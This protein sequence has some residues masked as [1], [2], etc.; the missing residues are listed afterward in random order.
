MVQVLLPQSNGRSGLQPNSKV[1]SGSIS[2]VILLT[3]GI[4][5]LNPV[6]TLYITHIT[7]P[8]PTSTH[9]RTKLNS[10]VLK[11]TSK[12]LNTHSKMASKLLS[13]N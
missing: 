7:T 13:L 1:A 9:G 6:L 8:Q 4:E 5:I 2:L 3:S 12:M 11:L 10:M